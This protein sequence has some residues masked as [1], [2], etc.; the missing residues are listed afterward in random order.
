MQ[1]YRLNEYLKEQFGGKVYKVAL[2]GGMTCPNRDG[3]ID[4]RGCIFCAG[5][6]GSFAQQQ[7]LSVAMQIENAKKR[8]EKV[9]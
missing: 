2:D 6:S 1:Y 8:I 9:F 3:N 7:S 4:T 5:G